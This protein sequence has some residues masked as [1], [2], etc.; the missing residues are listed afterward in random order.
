MNHLSDEDRR[1]IE[2]EFLHE[3]NYRRHERFWN[4]HWRFL[5]IFSPKT[6]NIIIYIECIVIGI[7]LLAACMYVL[8]LIITH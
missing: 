2:E 3:A 6:R 4:S 1:I 8:A 5:S 7:P